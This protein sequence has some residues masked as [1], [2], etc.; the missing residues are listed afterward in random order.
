MSVALRR[1]RI[2]EVGREVR[3]K[4]M[5]GQ[6]AI[7]AAVLVVAFAVNSLWLHATPWLPVIAALLVW[8]GMQ[9]QPTLPGVFQ[10]ALVVYAL[11]LLTAVILLP[12]GRRRWPVV[13]MSFLLF[14]VLPVFLPNFE[15][16]TLS[17]IMLYAMVAI[18]LNLLTGNSGQISLGHGAFLA[19]GVYTSAILVTK[20]GWP[21]LATVPVA[22]LV[23]ALFGLVL[24]VPST[25]LSGLYLAITS[26]ALAISVPAFLKWDTLFKLTGG[27]QGIRASNAQL[28]AV[29][30]F[31]SNFGRSL[32]DSAGNPVQG[33]TL[34]EWRYY[35]CFVGLVIVI[36]LAWNLLRSRPGRAFMALRD[37]EPAAEVMG[38]NLPTYKTLAFV[39]SAFFAGVGGAFF[40]LINQSVQPDTFSL[41]LSIQ[42]L[43]MIVIGGLGSISGSIIGCSVIVWL[44]LNKTSLPGP[45]DV[46]GLGHHLATNFQQFPLY[47]AGIYY[48][49]A[50]ILIMI[51]LPQGVGGA[52]YRLAGY[53][54]RE[55]LRLGRRTRLG[56]AASEPA[57]REPREAVAEPERR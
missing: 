7:L 38:I 45:A 51:F 26:I 20:S 22:G 56:E 16:G 29:P 36:V 53:P 14:A 33:L 1:C 25:R 52:I 27:V 57:L 48:G 8:I 4:D 54:Y 39:V 35:L 40:V 19:V 50:L 28:P 34:D 6:V 5:A 44:E 3:R 15:N 24:G 46:P 23:A 13:A 30:G 12:R 41:D 37:S 49:L 47:A 17:L 21:F 31:L 18:G 9:V 2:W 10:A 43:A 55:R 32:S 11:A 42:F